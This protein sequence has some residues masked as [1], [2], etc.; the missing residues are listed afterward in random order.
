LSEL[1]ELIQVP[2]CEPL[3]EPLEPACLAGIE[4]SCRSLSLRAADGAHGGP[5]DP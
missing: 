2:G 1:I 3:P 4:R 5:A